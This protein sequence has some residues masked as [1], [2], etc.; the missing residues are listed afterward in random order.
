[1]SCLNN[2]WR[3]RPLTRYN[4]YGS[5]Y[6]QKLNVVQV[7]SLGTFPEL[8]FAKKYLLSLAV[9]MSLPVTVFITIPYTIRFVTGPSALLSLIIATV[10]L[11][12]A[13][14]HIIELA[15]AL[16]KSCLLYTVKL[17]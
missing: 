5:S 14:L 1:M 17:S 3:R 15:Y 7:I 4:L 10:V 2:M 6:T 9:L 16:P 13:L 8:F 12:S 11:L